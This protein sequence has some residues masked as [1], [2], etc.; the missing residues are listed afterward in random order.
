[1]LGTIGQDLLPGWRFPPEYGRFIKTDQR[2]V[3][4]GSHIHIFHAGI[5]KI[6]AE[7]PTD[8]IHVVLHSYL[9]THPILTEL[10]DRIKGGGER[11]LIG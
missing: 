6:L 7:A 2:P 5:R 10:L 1:M 8:S 4:M 3:A 9:G 11:L